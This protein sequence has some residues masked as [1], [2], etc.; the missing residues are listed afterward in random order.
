M[1]TLDNTIDNATDEKKKKANRT[2]KGEGSLFK[3]GRVWTFKAPNGKQYSTGQQTKSEA[4]KFK[5]KKI[6]E[7]RTGQPE[8]STKAKKTTVHELLDAHLAHM[9]RKKRVSV[10][11]VAGQLD[12]HVRPVF[13]ERIASALVTK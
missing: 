1:S 11:E 7:L 12:K 4:V 5:H 2:D 6:E 13:G 8:V 9:R 10:E 3:R